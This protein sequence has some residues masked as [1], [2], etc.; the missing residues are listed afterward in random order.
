MHLLRLRDATEDDLQVTYEIT[1]NAMRGYV[2]ETWGT[3]N[4]EEQKQKHRLNFTPKTH[5]II[6]VEKEVA[7]FIAVEEFPSHV[8][9]VKLY[10]LAR[11]RGQ[12]IGSQVLEGVLKN[13]RA[14]G[15][16]VTLR[17]LRLNRRAQV[18]Y[19]KHGFH[20]TEESP[21]RLVMASGA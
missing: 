2:E 4:P 11:F 9:L 14:Q 8:W 15:K 21:E 16:P 18:L 5:R 1:E 20:V 12:G 13:A 3:W 7:G 17:V 10:V 6:L 19:E